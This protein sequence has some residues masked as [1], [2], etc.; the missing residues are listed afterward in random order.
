MVLDF[1]EYFG[2]TL[3]DNRYL[4]H[5]TTEYIAIEYILKNCELKFSTRESSHDPFEQNELKHVFTSSAFGPNGFVGFDSKYD[6]IREINNVRNKVKYACFCI[7]AD[8]LLSYPWD[9]G[10][11]RSRMWSQYANSHKGVCLVFDYKA[12]EKLSFEVLPATEKTW[13]INS[14]VGYNDENNNLKKVLEVSSKDHDLI[15]SNRVKLFCEA[16]LFTKLKDYENENEYR[17]C[18]YDDT[19]SKN[20][21]VNVKEAFR[22]IILGYNFPDVYLS[23]IKMFSDQLKIPVVRANWF[24][25]KPSFEQ[26]EYGV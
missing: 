20:I 18:I 3:Q 2:K 14:R 15:P 5:Y 19:D 6:Y 7:D 9:K 1:E 21:L 23:V 22:G 13:I 11:F 24:R 8:N 17:I 26:V 12:M 16:Y 4:F 10:C 25:G